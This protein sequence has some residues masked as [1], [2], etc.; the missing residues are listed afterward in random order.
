MET[1]HKSDFNPHVIMQRGKSRKEVSN[2][3]HNTRRKC[4]KS[5]GKKIGGIKSVKRGIRG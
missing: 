1:S 4:K 2:K 3:V 5:A